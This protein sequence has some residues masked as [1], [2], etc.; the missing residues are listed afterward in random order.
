MLVG[1]IQTSDPMIAAALPPF[2]NPA[3]QTGMM[4][5]NGEISRQGAMV[6][7]DTVFSTLLLA[8]TIIVPLLLIMRAPPP[9]AKPAHEMVGE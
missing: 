3:T 4:A 6:A 7:Y 1:N 5:L 9:V 8:S 2:L